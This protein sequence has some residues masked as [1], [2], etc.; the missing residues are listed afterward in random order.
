MEVGKVIIVDTSH[1]GCPISV[2]DENHRIQVNEVIQRNYCIIQS[3]IAYYLEVSKERVDPVIELLG[4]CK[5]YARWL[6]C[7][8]TE[9]N[10]RRRRDDYFQYCYRRRKLCAHYAYF[11]M[12]KFIYFTV[13]F[14][15][16][17]NYLLFNLFHKNDFSKKYIFFLILLH[18]EIMLGNY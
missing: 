5:I 9:E 2:T 4:Y 6:P 7:M 10:R 17:Y 11:P 18:R 13:I 1:S 15:H 16:T 8:L 3:C 12:L 14:I